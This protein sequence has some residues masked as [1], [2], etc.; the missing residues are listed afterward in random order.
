M[1]GDVPNAPAPATAPEQD[2][3]LSSSAQYASI[4]LM[5]Q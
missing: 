5:I 4:S 3:L 2:Y 1:L